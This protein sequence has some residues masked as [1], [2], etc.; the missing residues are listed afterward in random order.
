MDFHW[1]TLD[2]LPDLVYKISFL[3]KFIKIKKMIPF[4]I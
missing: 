1:G 2:L 4:I 3:K